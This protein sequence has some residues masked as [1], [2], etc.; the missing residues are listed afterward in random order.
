ME[1]SRCKDAAFGVF[2]V[3]G[4]GGWSERVAKTYACHNSRRSIAD[5]KE[6]HVCESSHLRVTQGTLHK[7]GSRPRI[8]L[9]AASLSSDSLLPEVAKD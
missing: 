1:I 3:A 8:S 7:S 9:A 4:E 2:W 5:L 6:I